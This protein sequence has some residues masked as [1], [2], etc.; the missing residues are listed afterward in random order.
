MQ[1]GAR[2]PMAAILVGVVAAVLPAAARPVAAA[3]F[4]A[5]DSGYHSYPEMVADIKA[6]ESAHPDI[7]HVFSIGKSYQGRDIWAAKVSDN[8]AVDEAEPEVLIDALHHAREHLTVEQALYVLHM[9]ANGYSQDA[10]VKRLVD[11]RE[12]WI[13]FAVNPDGF[14]YDLTGSPYRAWRKNRQPNAG[15]TYVGTDLNRNYD[16]DWGCCGGSSAATSAWNYR[17]PGPFSAPETRA[18]R[19]FVNS[20]VVGGVQQIRTHIT[21]HTNDELILWPYGHTKTDVP[22]DMTRDDHAAFVAFGSTM[23]A[24][25]GYTAQ[26]SSDLYITDGDEIDWLYGRY[27]IFTFTFELYPTEQP[28]VWLDHYPPDEIIPR[29]T[30]RNRTAILHLIDRADCPY[31]DAHLEKRDCG[32]LY[33]DFE[34]TRPGW[35]FNPWGTDTSP[36]GSWTRGDPKPIS[37]NGPKQLGD[38]ASGRRAMVTGAAAGTGPYAN[39]LDGTTSVATPPVTLPASVGPLTFSYYFAHTATSTAS[40]AFRVYIWDTTSGTRTRIYQEVA[41]S[42]DDDAAWL[43]RSIALTPWASKTV[44]I[45]FVAS[46]GSPANEVEAAF[47]DVRIQRP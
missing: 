23:A 32:P 2:L 18:V 42:V 41:T 5:Y 38:T 46:D 25:N 22:S 30:A 39:D 27:R 44:R 31:L 26:Q 4:P 12:V 17:G 3:D 13:I 14:E 43:S 24:M 36:S 11:S 9:L 15:S 34:L 40:D 45:V 8:V 7:V 19:D 20:R 37:L 6:T 1:R 47:D 33:D 16:Y 21:L 35:L 10:T 29:E 28:T